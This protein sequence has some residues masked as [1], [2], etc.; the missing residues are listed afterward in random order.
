MID[1]H[2]AHVL[3]LFAATAFGSADFLG[4]LAT[5]RGGLAITAL[6]AQLTGTAMLAAATVMQSGSP[7]VH[8]LLWGAVAGVAD[9]AG[10]LLLFR[11][12]AIGEMAGVAPIS[13]VVSSALPVAVGV[14]FGDRP[15]AIQWAGIAIGLVAIAAVSWSVSPGDRLE[16]RRRLLPV[17][18]GAAAGGGFAL[19]YILFSRISHT[20]GTAPVLSARIGSTLV[21]IVWIACMANRRARL[22]AGP[23]QLVMAAVTGMLA[24]GGNLLLVLA[25]RQGQ[26]GLVSVLAS[27]YPAVTVILAMIVLHERP[28]VWQLAGIG[29]AIAAVGMIAAG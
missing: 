19:Y 18:L 4:G 3:A 16:R 29:A 11:A 17:L 6:T 15:A 12:L 23:A 22:S 9:C 27:L 2:G 8:D 5:R 21:I 28:R 25:V 14:L 1:S 24:S 10:L 7:T 20:S 13:G 26:L